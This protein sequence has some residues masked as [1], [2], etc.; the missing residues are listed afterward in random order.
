MVIKNSIEK[1]S[2]SRMN[3]HKADFQW[4]F[5]F[6]FMKK[7]EK[8]KTFIQSLSY[9]SFKFSLVYPINGNRI[10]CMRI[11]QC[12]H[13]EQHKHWTWIKFQFYSQFNVCMYIC[14]YALSKAN[15]PIPIVWDD[16]PHSPLMHASIAVLN[17]FHFLVLIIPNKPEQNF[18]RSG[19]TFQTF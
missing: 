3:A 15:L 5:I 19:Y 13:W 1:L 10:K 4:F 14:T 9:L 17:L 12:A 11:L 2:K 16:F 8:R 6:I 7:K 18:Y